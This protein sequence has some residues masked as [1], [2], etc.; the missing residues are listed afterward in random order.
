M[1]TLLEKVETELKLPREQVIEEGVHRYL[2]GELR[3]LSVE[4]SK[5]CFKYGVN[6]FNGLMEKLERGKVSELECFD[7]L[8]RLEYLE[9]ERE[10]VQR[11]LEEEDKG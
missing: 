8:T 7:D 10:K 3:N 9:I 4:L 1:P 11:I 5:L 2:E 6:S